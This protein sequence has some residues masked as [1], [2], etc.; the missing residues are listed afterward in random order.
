MFLNWFYTLFSIYFISRYFFLSFLHFIFSVRTFF[1]EPEMDKIIWLK[2]LLTPLQLGGQCT[3]SVAAS[4]R[5]GQSLPLAARS[6][7]LPSFPSPSVALTLIP[8]VGM[9]C[10]TWCYWW[11]WILSPKAPQAPNAECTGCW[12]SCPLYCLSLLDL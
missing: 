1:S 2:A 6:S 10:F 9:A 3:C 7:Q 5:Q 11:S 12:A 8:W 4:F